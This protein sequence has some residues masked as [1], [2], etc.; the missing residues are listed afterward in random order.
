MLARRS[1]KAKQPSRALVSPSSEGELKLD[2]IVDVGAALDETPEEKRNR[3]E[4]RKQRRMERAEKEVRI[5]GHGEAL[6]D[7]AFH[8][9]AARSR[10]THFAAANGEEGGLRGEEE[11]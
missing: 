11:D 4:S 9:D 2:T 8:G 6:R 3:K 7:S 5:A 1:R 10:L